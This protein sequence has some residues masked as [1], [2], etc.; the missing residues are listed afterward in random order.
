[1]TIT[2]TDETAGGVDWRLVDDA[3]RTVS[4]GRVHGPAHVAWPTAFETANQVRS[5]IAAQEGRNHP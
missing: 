5:N 3:G 2:I 1:M 4:G